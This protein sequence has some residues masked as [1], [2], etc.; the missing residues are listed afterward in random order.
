MMAGMWILRNASEG[1]GRTD[2]FIQIERLSAT[3]N[4]LMPLHFLHFLRVWVMLILKY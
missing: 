2:G 3:L 1:P 4:Q